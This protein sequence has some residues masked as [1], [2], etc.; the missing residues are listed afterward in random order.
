MQVEGNDGPSEIEIASLEDKPGLNTDLWEI[1]T[2]INSN[3]NVCSIS[4]DLDSVE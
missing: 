2:G 3:F 1:E 4:I